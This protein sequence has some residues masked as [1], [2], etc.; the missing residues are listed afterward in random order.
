MAERPIFG[1]FLE[2]QPCIHYLD[3]TFMSSITLCRQFYQQLNAVIEITGRIPKA[4][5][6]QQYHASAP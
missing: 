2:T 6:F 5:C 1:K 4:I 3:R